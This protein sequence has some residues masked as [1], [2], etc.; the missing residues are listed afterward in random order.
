MSEFSKAYFSIA[1]EIINTLKL[2]TYSGFYIELEKKISFPYPQYTSFIFLSKT[3][4]VN[5]LWTL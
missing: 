1:E 5:S 2:R 4:N 3:S